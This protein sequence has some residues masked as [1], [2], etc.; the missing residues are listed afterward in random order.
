MQIVLT[1][2]VMIMK[3]RQLTKTNCPYNT[4]LQG[5]MPSFTVLSNDG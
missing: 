4:P 2:E 1:I 5:T 3:M